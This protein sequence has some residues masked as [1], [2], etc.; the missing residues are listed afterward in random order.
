MNQGCI[1]IILFNSWALDLGK[2]IQL[3]PALVA[4]NWWLQVI[5]L[6]F[7]DLQHKTHHKVLIFLF[8]IACESTT[9]QYEHYLA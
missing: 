3:S 6:G 4:K 7:T 2:Q 8:I 9:C 1:F 5:R